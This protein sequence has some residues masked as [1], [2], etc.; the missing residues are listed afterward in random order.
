[1]KI[2][3]IGG[4]FELI[5][6][7]TKKVKDKN[8]IKSIGDDTAIV[9]V[10]KKNLLYTTDMFVENDHFSLK[11]FSPRQIGIKSIEA[12][13]SDIAAMGG[14]PKYAL[15]SLCLRRDIP[16]EFVMDF[17][18]GIWESCSKYGIDVI[19]GDTTHGALVVVNVTLVGEVSKENISLRSD[20]KAGDF[21]MV[22]GDLGKSTAGLNVFLQRIKGHAKVKKQHCEP[23][24]RLDKSVKIAKYVNAMEDVSDGLAEEL[25]HIC[26]ESKVGCVIFKDNIPIS[27]ETRRAAKAVG[28]SA[29]DYALFGGEDFEL[30]YTVPEKYLNKVSGYLVG[31]IR[32]K[33]GVYLYS[34][35]KEQPVKK[36]GFNH[37]K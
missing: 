35:G 4:E 25:K 27:E 5:K 11:Y 37:F 23:R 3:Q 29:V 2:S 32:K 19:G 13:V 20:A 22:S 34:K 10:G 26:E 15:I 21:I 28:K 30:V 9:K 16:Y 1:M 17:Y 7:I 8:V 12:N 18:K 33:K 24:A 36:S 14:K 6:R 31:E